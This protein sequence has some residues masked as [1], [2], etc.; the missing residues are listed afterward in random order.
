MATN[1][2]SPANVERRDSSGRFT[3]NEMPASAERERSGQQGS[4]FSG[5]AVPWGG[6]LAANGGVWTNPMG[7]PGYGSLYTGTYD[8][9]RWM[10][11]HP[12]IQFV[13]AIRTSP[14]IASTWEYA[15]ALGRTVPDKWVEAV[16]ACFNRIRQ[17]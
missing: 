17:P 2:V 12:V 8:T 3:E 6:M 9:Y 11:Q 5:V 16:K 7:F 13:R 1:G 14:I 4:R 10:L 15:P